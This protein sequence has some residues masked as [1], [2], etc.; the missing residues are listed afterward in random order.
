M[1][2]EQSG[3]QL[4]QSQRS[5]PSGGGTGFSVMAT[6]SSGRP[7]L[8]RVVSLVQGFVLQT[9]IGIE[10]SVE[11][12]AAAVTAVLDGALAQESARG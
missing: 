6:P 3:P 11:S 12:F 5:W 7:S 4:A 10:L 1:E 8:S 9:A 2:H